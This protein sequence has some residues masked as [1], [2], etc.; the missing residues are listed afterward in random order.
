MSAPMGDNVLPKKTEAPSNARVALNLLA[1]AVLLYI[2]LVGIQCLSGGIK[3]LGSGVMNEYLGEDMNPFLALLC[4][5]LA[6]TLVQSSSVTTSLI[7][8]LVASGQ[9]AVAAAVPM[10]MGSNI[11]TTVTNTIAALAHAN[12]STEFRRAFA[13][14]T[15][16]DF[17]NFLAVSLFLPLEILT[18][19]L[20]GKG[21]LEA[22]AL[23]CAAFTTASGV[24][25]YTYK[26]PL[27]AAFKAGTKIVQEAVESLGFNEEASYILLSVVGCVIIFATLAGIV[28]AMRGI[29]MSRMERY[30][31]KMLGSGGA[32]AVVIGIVLTVMV[33]SSSIT[34]SVLVPLAGA[35]LITVQQIYPITIGANIGTT[36]TAMLASLAV[37]GADAGP[38]RQ[39]AFVHLIFNLLGTL[40]FYVPSSTRR[41]PVRLAEGLAEFAVNRKKWAVAYVFFVFYCLPAIIFFLSR[42]F[43]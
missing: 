11:G 18:R 38:A 40:V 27:K 24:G 42:I 15:C 4:G 31:N 35:G 22:M 34:T 26:S 41:W 43:G 33:Q 10:I 36:V 13:A 16:H 21:I 20:W 1:V 39:I 37:S 32:L 17:F 14:A 29:V 19:S 28:R 12:R 9:V 23:K 8:G 25:G 30:I 6:T 7:V 3:G 2:F 5:I